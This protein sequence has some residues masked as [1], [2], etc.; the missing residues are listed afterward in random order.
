MLDD[1]FGVGALFWVINHV[2]AFL[3]YFGALLFIGSVSNFFVANFVGNHGNFFRHNVWTQTW[4]VVV[5][6]VEAASATVVTQ[7]VPRGAVRDDFTARDR[8]VSTACYRCVHAR[9]ATG[10]ATVG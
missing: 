10:I 8:A 7:A 1:L 9:T 6:G 4:R 3:R 5:R 2:D